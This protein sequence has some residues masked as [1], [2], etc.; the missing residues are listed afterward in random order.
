MAVDTNW[1]K[2]RARF[3]TV[4]TILF[5]G[6]LA[7]A[8][9]SRPDTW[10]YAIGFLAAWGAVVVSLLLLERASEYLRRCP[11]CD[12][13]GF[14][15]CFESEKGMPDGDH[16]FQVFHCRGCGL[17]RLECGAETRDLDQACWEQQIQEW[18]RE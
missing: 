14:V 12:R 3:F 11:R 7:F 15:P 4:V 18:Q 17:Y 5:F 6:A 1:E 9:A 8:L 10:P 2:G 13:K 16:F